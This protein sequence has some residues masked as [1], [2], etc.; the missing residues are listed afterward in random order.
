M[1]TEILVTPEE[2][3]SHMSDVQ[4]EAQSARDS[5]ESLRTRLTSLADQFRGQ[6]ATRFDERFNEWNTSAQSLMESLDALG[7]FL[8]QT[9]DAMESTD[10]QLAGG[11]G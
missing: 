10:Q 9:A 4:G 3:R 5:F 6:A 1:A 8:G 7:G 11:L 2:L